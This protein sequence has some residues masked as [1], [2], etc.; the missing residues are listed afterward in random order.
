MNQENRI[1][2]IGAGLGG[3]VAGSLLQQ[4]GHDV[5]IYE[6][7]PEFQRLGAGINLGP[8]VMKVL[9]AIGV[10]PRLLDIGL[11]P[12]SWLSRDWDTGRV[13]FKY[14][15]RD[16][17][18][19]AF[20]APYL[21]IHRG[22]FH[23]ILLDTVAPGTVEFGKRLVGLDEGGATVGL[24]F[25][26]GSTEEA[27]IVIGADGIN[28]M[29]REVMLGPE[30]PVYSG[31]VAHRSII[32][33]HLLGDLKPPDFTKWWTD[34]EHDDTHIVVYFLDRNHEEI[35]FVTGVA[36]PEWDHGLQFVDADLDE[37]R[38][39]FE[40]FHPEVQ[41]LLDV[42]PG[43]TKWPLWDREPLPFWGRGRIVLIGDACHPMKP[44]MGQGAAI[45]IED[46]AILVRC[47]AQC[48]D[49][50][51]AAFSLYETSRKDRASLCQHHSRENKWLRDAMDPT[52]VFDYDAME[53]G[54]GPHSPNAP[55]PG[56]GAA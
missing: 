7:A 15:F 28:S 54:L 14:P 33:A 27:D 3:L 40:G 4:R 25:G 37:L 44:H 30:L 49:D 46:A 43:A 50:H 38:A 51:E 48:G 12:T 52:W 53:I 39:S 36:E 41:R 26:D 32:P 6:Q 31:Y 19:A 42:C 11:R 5:R 55:S 9:R 20:G 1:A 29:A 2:V 45:A 24:A 56:A 8:N 21:L 23:E 10:E 13:K 34:D 17:A 35:Y 47:L 22:D 16:A 18:E